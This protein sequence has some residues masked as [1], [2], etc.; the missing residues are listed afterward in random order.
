MCLFYGHAGTK[1]GH[2]GTDVD[3]VSHKACSTV[4]SQC[5]L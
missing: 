2:T 3:L 1:E 5:E 4:V